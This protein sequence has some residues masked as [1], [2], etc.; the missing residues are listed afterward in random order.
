MKTVALIPAVR[1]SSWA[2]VAQ[3]PAAFLLALC[4][5]LLLFATPL[6]AQET[7]AQQAPDVNLPQVEA[8]ETVR[9][10]ITGQEPISRADAFS[11][12][13][14]LGFNVIDPGGIPTSNV[15]VIQQRGTGNTADVTQRGLDNVAALSQ[16]GDFN[17][18]TLLQDGTGNVFGLSV[19][20]NNNKLNAKQVGNDN[21]HVVEYTGSDLNLSQSLPFLRPFLRRFGLDQQPLFSLQVGNGNQVVQLNTSPSNPPYPVVQFGNGSIPLI[22]RH[23]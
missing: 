19:T 5:A 23:N 9:Q 3:F 15:A 13:D 10:S 7:R 4:C 11:R 8:L 20:G 1:R 16:V 18:T 6:R 21:Y 2:S 14:E 12:L 17:G 22:I